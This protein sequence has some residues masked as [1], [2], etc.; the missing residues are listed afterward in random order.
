MELSAATIVAILGGAAQI[1]KAVAPLIEKGVDVFNSDDQA[2]IKAALVDLGQAN[3]AIYD[4]V[5]EKLG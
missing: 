5:Q 4:R 3:D 2:M 1:A